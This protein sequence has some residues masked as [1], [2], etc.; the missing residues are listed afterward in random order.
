MKTKLFF[1]GLFIALATLFA[2]TINSVD[3]NKEDFP[4][5]CVPPCPTVTFTYG[6]SFLSD[7]AVCCT[8]NPPGT[9]T[10]TYPKLQVYDCNH[11]VHDWIELCGA[12]SSAI[13]PCLGGDC[14]GGCAAGLYL[15]GYD[16][17][18]PASGTSAV[19]TFPGNSCVCDGATLAITITNTG[20]GINI[21]FSCI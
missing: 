5:G 17:P 11:A 19:L 8:P 18:I 3:S 2:F 10:K 21:D 1:A 13:L 14:G 20:S 6:S 16:I 12:P 15:M 7:L 9:G 4:Q